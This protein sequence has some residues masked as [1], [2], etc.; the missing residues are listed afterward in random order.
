MLLVYR[1]DNLKVEHFLNTICYFAVEKSLN[2]ILGDLNINDFHDNIA[3]TTLLALGFQ[4]FVTAPTHI[5][6][7]II[8]HIYFRNSHELSHSLSTFVSS[9]YY[10]DHQS[11][12]LQYNQS[13]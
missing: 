8:D 9:N 7:G 6:G 12:F 11:V 3:R 5:R 1:R 2:I 10:S 13:N 4:Q